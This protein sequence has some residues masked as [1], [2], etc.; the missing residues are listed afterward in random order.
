MAKLTRLLNQKNAL[1]KEVLELNKI[2]VELN[3]VINALK[4]E[5]YRLHNKSEQHKK[6]IEKLKAKIKKWEE[7]IQK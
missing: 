4:R 2:N 3:T 7:N 1:L 5:N 6:E